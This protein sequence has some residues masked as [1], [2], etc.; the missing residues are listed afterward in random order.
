MRY[1]R[2]ILSVILILVFGY[3]LAGELLMP[4]N[5]PRNG[6][7]CEKLPGDNWFEVKEDGTKVPFKVPG[8]TDGDIVLETTLP[9]T[10]DKDS[11]VLCFR[12]MDMEIYI[13]GELREALKTEDYPLF[14]DRSSECYVMASIY[15]EDAGKSLVVKYE[16]NSGMVYEV[17]IGT[18]LGILAYLF[19]QFGMELFV[20]L[21]I[22]MLGL[23]C[24]IASVAYKY[25]HKQYLEMEHLALGTVLGACWVLSNSIFRQ[26]YTSNIS[27]MSDMPFLMVMIMPL[28]FLIFINSMQKG[29]YNKALVFASTLVVV[30]FTICITL[31]VAGTVSLIDSFIFSALCACV[32]IGIMFATLF[33]DLKKHLISSYRYVAIGFVFLA[34]AAVVQIVAYQ[35]AH[36]G[37]FSGLFMAIGLFGFLIFAIIHTIKQLIGIR[38]E[39]NE[40][41]HISKAKDDFL[42][43]MSHEI[44]TPLN[45]ILGMD[46]M[47][48]RD[49]KDGTVR[50]YALDI[51]SAGNTLLA[52]I[53]DI[54][55]LSKIES[56]SFE[57]IPIDYD[58]ASV[59]NDILN[60]TR[61]KA[62]EKEL[63][64][65][66]VIAENIPSMLH[67]DE[68]RIRQI[69]LNIINNAIK[70]TEK[71]HVDIDVSV[72]SGD[73]PD[74]VVLVF[75]VSD[76]GIG[77]KE[78]DKE[79]LFN[80]FER[81][82]KKKNRNIEGTG[83]GLHIT[84]RLARM[85]DGYIEFDS[86]YGK[87]ST[88]TVYLPQP[89]VNPEPIGEFSKAVSDF[90]EN[91]EVD[92]TNLYAP[93]AHILV[94][95]DNE[96]N[97][98]VMEGLLRD[99]RIRIDLALSGPECIEKVRDNTYDCILLD[100]MM[101]DMNGE[102][103]LKIM[104]QEDILGDIPVIALTAD[105]IV[106]AK[107]SYISKGFTDYM[108]KPV[109]YD[110][111][112]QLL[113]RYIPQEKQMALQKNKELPTL[114]IWGDDPEMIRIEKE[115][116]EGLYKCVCVTGEQ[117]ME[118][119]LEKKKPDA[120]MKVT[121]KSGVE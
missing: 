84:E 3:I 16:Y 104:K 4:Y 38:I 105:A 28:P 64:Y 31:F 21:L 41:M 120:V 30:N 29:R 114:L 53:N 91:I 109:K 96:M 8:K 80:S 56:G 40:M 76:T 11:A 98:D 48:I 12:G 19:S 74:S 63:G 66:L 94:V 1:F 117:A 7:I 55:D 62:I 13:D 115:R 43:N 99:T 110:V 102:T 73:A 70:Y 113:K 116:L 50:K 85:M 106:G 93:K 51:K 2:N 97:L 47:I 121:M 60:L 39:A 112:E 27:V 107:E 100:Q 67:G 89:V 46:E 119:Y 22:L 65:N 44:R 34:F 61:P 17:Y 49:T 57:I 111:L 5:S 25:I 77:I 79:K 87:G 68:I 37:V 82:D 92:E 88:F 6:D 95:D 36:N 45:G 33:L 81:L 15:K 32:G 18:R 35:F 10:L 90:I 69:M 20:G 9:E 86:E 23:I 108:S 75:R 54:L 52:I 42:A 14:G 58:I 24:Y 71:G 72:K 118:R 78:E 83:L 26:L 103:T 101:P 59:L